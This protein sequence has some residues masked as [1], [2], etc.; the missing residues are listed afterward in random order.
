[1]PQGRPAV[2]VLGCR[3]GSA[4]LVRRAR[5]GARTFA[6]EGADTVVAC[7]GRR[8]SGVVE[9]DDIARILAGAG[10]PEAAILRERR[11][12][13][14]V[15]NAREA[16]RLL[17]DKPVIV[18]TCAWHLP[19]ARRVFERVGLR[20]VGAVGVPAPDGGLL[21]A[22]YRRGR[23]QVATWKDMLR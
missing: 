20:V 2:C 8:W 13:D 3:S 14:T 15:G 17:A 5:A 10:V 18:V 22:M 4:A 21:T 16:A 12:L 19:R 11:S 9:A 23:E 1:M 6:D 7:G